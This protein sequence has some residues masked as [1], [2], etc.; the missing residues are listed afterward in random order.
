MAEKIRAHIFVSGKVQG[1]F[2][3]ERTR[4]KA[5]KLKVAG[6]VKNLRDG[7]VEAMFE[8]EKDRVEKIVGWARSGPIFAKVDSLDVVWEDFQAEF[9]GFEIRYDL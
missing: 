8:G 1:V 2:Y 3:R 7:R 5:E 6:W 9:S 4:Q